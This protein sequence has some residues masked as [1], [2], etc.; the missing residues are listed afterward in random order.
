[1]KSQSERVLGYM[2]E[3]G[4]ISVLDEFLG[5]IGLPSIIYDLRKAGY[6]IGCAR[7]FYRINGKERYYNVY[8]LEGQNNATEA[9]KN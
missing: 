4:S 1:M 5:I 3:N 6:Q 8:F 2:K 9:N 7:R